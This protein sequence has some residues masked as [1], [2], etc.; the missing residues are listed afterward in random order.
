MHLRMDQKILLLG[1][2]YNLLLQHLY[3][4]KICIE[5]VKTIYGPAKTY[6][7]KHLRYKNMFYL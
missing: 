3:G 5:E 2:K 1:S 4:E 7:G 6:Y